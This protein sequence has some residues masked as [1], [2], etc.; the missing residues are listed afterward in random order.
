MYK[1]K[2]KFYA[3]NGSCPDKLF[4]FR[5]NGRQD[6]IKAIDRFSKKVTIKAAWL[7]VYHNKVMIKNERII[8]QIPK[9]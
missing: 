2:I 6:A 4:T 5:V 9:L 7:C 1:F 8:L 3:N